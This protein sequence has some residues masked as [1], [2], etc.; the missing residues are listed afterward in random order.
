MPLQSKN[1]NSAHQI[2]GLIVFIFLLAQFVVG[3]M[4]HRQSK[5]DQKPTKLAPVH[6]WMGR[7]TIVLGIANGFL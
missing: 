7:L 6:V 2:I 5:K 4:H 1:F 3:F